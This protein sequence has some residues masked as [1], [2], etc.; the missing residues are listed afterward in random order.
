M[1]TDNKELRD[2]KTEQAGMT[3]LHETRKHN[4]PIQIDPPEVSPGPYSKST[5]E[6]D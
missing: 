2:L 5:L 6:N 1:A 4:K 3:D